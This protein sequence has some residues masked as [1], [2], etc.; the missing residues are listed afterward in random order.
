[1]KLLGSQLWSQWLLGSQHLLPVMVDLQRSS[2]ME[3]RVSTSTHIIRTRL[4]LLWWASLRPATPIQIIGEKSL[5]EGSSE[6]MKGW[7]FS[8][9][10][11]NKITSIT[12]PRWWLHKGLCMY[13]YTWKK[14]SERLL[15]LAG[16]YS[17]WKHVSKLERRETRRYLEMF[18]SLKFRDLVSVTHSSF[19]PLVSV[20]SPTLLAS[21]FRFA[22]QF[23]SAG[24]GWA[25]SK[26][27]LDL[28]SI[29]C[30]VEFRF[31]TSWIRL[32]FH[33][34]FGFVLVLCYYCVGCFLDISNNNL[35]VWYLRSN[36]SYYFWRRRHKDD[37]PLHND[38]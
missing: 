11:L 13:R 36:N 1:M 3:F 37:Q 35:S 10:R 12:S 30:T 24:N 21:F 7:P 4:Q 15:T 25:L 22:G 32:W 34:W 8:L 16:V 33:E 29:C 5:K 26:P 2:R 17:F 23:N 14:Y 38:P 31:V 28:D 18:Y 20:S 27:W 19:S 6:S 9:D